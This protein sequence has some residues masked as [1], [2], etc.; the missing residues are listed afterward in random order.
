LAGEIH[1]SLAQSF[2]G[3]T[4]QLEMAK[5]V[6]TDRD[7][8]TLSYVERANDPARFELTEARRFILSLQP[9]SIKDAGLIFSLAGIT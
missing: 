7:N 3:I 1:D 5:E 4:M 9:I 2:T 6:M 8:H